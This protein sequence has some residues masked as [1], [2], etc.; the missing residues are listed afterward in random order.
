[1]FK[2]KMTQI[3]VNADLNYNYQKHCFCYVCKEIYC[4]Y[5]LDVDSITKTN[6]RMK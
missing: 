1:M 6:Y 5:S 2:L 4:L 3:Y